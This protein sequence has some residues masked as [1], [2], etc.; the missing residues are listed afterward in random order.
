MQELILRI[1]PDGQTVVG[2]YNDKLPYRQLGE[3]EAV[4]ATDVRLNK[5]GLWEVFSIFEG[6]TLD[7]RFTNRSDAIAHEVSYLQAN[8]DKLCPY[9]NGELKRHSSQDE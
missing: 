6:K 8:L 5:D 4:R 1:S 2:L 3:I 9:L 7:Q